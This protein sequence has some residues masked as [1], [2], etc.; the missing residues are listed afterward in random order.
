MNIAI[1]H[2][3]LAIRALEEECGVCGAYGYTLPIVRVLD[4]LEERRTRLPEPPE[5]GPRLVVVSSKEQV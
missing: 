1:A 3:K 2:L 4:E 5:N